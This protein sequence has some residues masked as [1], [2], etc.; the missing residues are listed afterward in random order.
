MIILL[1]SHTLLELN[2][3]NKSK[4][5]GNKKNTKFINCFATT[6]QL[7]LLIYT[8][9]LPGNCVSLTNFLVIKRN[10]LII[11]MIHGNAVIEKKKK[12]KF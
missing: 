11:G 5:K 3:E 12:H 8:L 2:I 6:E 7:V 9:V 4:V 10:K 1:Y